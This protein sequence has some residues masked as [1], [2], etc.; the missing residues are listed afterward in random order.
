M[1]ANRVAERFCTGDAPPYE[2]Y[3]A[4]ARTVPATLRNPLYHWTHLEL[5]RY[6]GV[7][8]LL[9][10]DSA[11]SVWDAA[12]ACLQQEDLSARGI[13]KKFD[14]RVLCTVDDPCDDLNVARPCGFSGEFPVFFPHSGRIRRF[15]CIRRVNSMR[16]LSAWKRP[17][18]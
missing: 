4:W 10:E 14:V 9:D 12:K 2:K 1:R 3:L 13:L 18:M 17:A 5:K 16:G 15:W 11:K 8:V 7:G 6:F